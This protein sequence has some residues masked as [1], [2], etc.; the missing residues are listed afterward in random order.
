VPLYHLFNLTYIV[1]IN[2]YLGLKGQN[3]LVCNRIFGTQFC[4]DLTSKIQ[5][6]LPFS[7]EELKRAIFGSEGSGAPDPYGFSFAFYRHFF[8]LVKSDLMLV[9]HHFLNL[10][11]R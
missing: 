2:L 5:L 9:L 10:V 3:K 1:T 4:L 7:E 11:L 8:D 6:E